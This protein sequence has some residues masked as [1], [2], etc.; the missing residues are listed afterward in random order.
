VTEKNAMDATSRAQESTIA[1][2]DLWSKYFQDQWGP[3][4]GRRDASAELEPVAQFAAGTGARVANFL[5][6]VAAG[7]VAWLYANSASREPLRPLTLVPPPDG[8]HELESVE[9]AA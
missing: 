4:F 1:N 6:L 3:L 8:G 9:D 2:A 5:T 7:P